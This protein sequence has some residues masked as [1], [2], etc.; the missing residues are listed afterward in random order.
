MAQVGLH[1]T[2]V[3]YGITLHEAARVARVVEH[4]HAVVHGRGLHLQL[5]QADGGGKK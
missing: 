4:Q 3:E 2:Q 1:V 5:V